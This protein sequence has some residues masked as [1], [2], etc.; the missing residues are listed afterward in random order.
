MPQDGRISGEVG[1]VY[2]RQ[3]GTSYGFSGSAAADEAPT[4][5]VQSLRKLNDSGL[6]EH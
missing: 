2:D 3:T 5:V 1:K 4:K 6:I